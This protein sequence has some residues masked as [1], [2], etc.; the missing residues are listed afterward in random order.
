[1]TR[2]SGRCHCGFVRFEVEADIDHARIC[3]CSIC[4]KRGALNFRVPNDALTLHTPLSEL[5]L[6]EWGSFT[7]KDYFCPHCGILAFRRPAALTRGERA[8]GQTE[9][10][11]WAV[12][13]R[14]L[15]GFDT[16]GIPVRHIPGRDI[17]FD[18]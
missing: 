5:T 12:N 3:N 9:F 18:A 13:L 1:M 2:Y 4:H 7:A 8:Q 16:D 14:C 17:A 11:G 6:Y 15:D 10:D